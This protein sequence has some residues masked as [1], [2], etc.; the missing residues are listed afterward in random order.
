[1]TSQ[2]AGDMKTIILISALLA[3]S[4]AQAINADYCHAVSSHIV[5][6]YAAWLDDPKAPETY[7]KAALNSQHVKQRYG[8]GDMIMYYSG[9]VF[10][11][12]LQ[13]AYNP[14]E[15]VKR[16]GVPI[17]NTCLRDLPDWAIYM[18]RKI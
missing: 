18:K 3:N 15:I 12:E 2:E 4:P 6:A 8:L 5:V 14:V 11:D 16:L 7:L 1:M 17:Y 13:R 10:N 9:I